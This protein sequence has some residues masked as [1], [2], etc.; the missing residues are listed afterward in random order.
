MKTIEVEHGM[1]DGKKRLLLYFPYDQDLIDLVKTIPGARWSRP[2][3]CWHI[4]Y[5]AGPVEQLNERFEGRLFFDLAEPDQGTYHPT[6]EKCTLLVPEEMIK[7]L[8]LRQYSHNTIRTYTSLFK[9]FMHYYPDKNLDE[10]TEEEIRDYLIYL[11]DE[12]N[13]SQSHQNQ[14]INAIKFYYE[15]VLGQP[16]KKYYI[17]RPKREKKLPV[18]CSVEEI[19]VILKGTTNL[20][21]RCILYLIY[22]AG[23]RLSEVVYLRPADIDSDRMTIHIRHAKGKKDR[24]S[25]LS[26]KTLI[27]LREYYKEYRPKI[28]LFEGQYDNQYSKRSVQNILKAALRTTTIRKRVTVHTLRHS[29]ATHLLEGGVDLR[30]I[31]NFLGHESTRTTQI[32]T[33]VTKKGIEKIK[34]PLDNLDI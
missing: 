11:V 24:I 33:H 16:I 27:L 25:L 2:L 28:W 29:F 3:K 5:S 8:K 13:V 17:Q 4:S 18:V 14:S 34:S 19:A 9:R 7:T 12:K 23:L 30:Y 20:K 32:Y 22:S 31:Q 26:E 21:H 1:V 10:V 15:K 6:T